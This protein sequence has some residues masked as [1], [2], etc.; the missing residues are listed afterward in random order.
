MDFLIFLCLSKKLT[1]VIL[2][3]YL[4]E[5]SSLVASSVSIVFTVVFP[6]QNTKLEFRRSA[7][8]SDT[9]YFWCL[10][11]VMQNVNNF[12]VVSGQC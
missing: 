6:K 2:N 8:F 9:I 5:L 10:K 4:T 12:D 1:Q 7:D 3:R 11:I